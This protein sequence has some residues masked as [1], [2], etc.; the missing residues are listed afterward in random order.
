MKKMMCLILVLITVIVSAGCAAT[1]DA[2]VATPTALSKP[3]AASSTEMTEVASDTK[4]ASENKEEAA[5]AEETAGAEETASAE[6]TSAPADSKTTEV[7]QQSTDKPDW[8]KEIDEGIERTMAML[9]ANK[10]I[11]YVYCYELCDI[12]NEK[13]RAEG[14]CEL[15]YAYD[16]Q[17]VA[18]GI[19]TDFMNRYKNLPE[20][21]YSYFATIWFEPQSVIN[22]I[23][24]KISSTAKYLNGQ[25][26]SMVAG[27]YADDEGSYWVILLY[28]DPAGS[29]SVVIPREEEPGHGSTEAEETVQVEE[30]VPHTEDTEI[31]CLESLL[32]TDLGDSDCGDESIVTP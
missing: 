20:P 32:R 17:S 7:P 1:S 30:T 9:E 19:V 26:T 13:R 4:L 5:D 15:T 8:Q 10:G 21:G 3:E 14:A 25:Y 27:H 24:S 31:P 6:Q 18:D 29:G 28:K 11:H 12:I 22:K 16:K 2:D 23:E